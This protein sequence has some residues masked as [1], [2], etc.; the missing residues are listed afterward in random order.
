MHHRVTVFIICVCVCVC[1]C[2]CVCVCGY[3][4]MRVGVD[5]FLL[6]ATQRRLDTITCIQKVGV[7]PHIKCYKTPKS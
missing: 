2:M 3:V 4:C 1:V 6:V 5:V 7:L